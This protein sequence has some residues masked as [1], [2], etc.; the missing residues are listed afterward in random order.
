MVDVDEVR[1]KPHHQI[2][3]YGYSLW[4][5]DVQSDRIQIAPQ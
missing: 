5:I 2:T 1:F 4:S 3:N